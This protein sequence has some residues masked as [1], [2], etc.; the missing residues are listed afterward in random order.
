MRRL[1][2]D[3]SG[4][5]RFIVI[6]AGL[7]ILASPCRAQ[8]ATVSGFV[9]DASDGQPL[10]GA[11]VALRDPADGAEAVPRYG[12]AANTDGLYLVR[13]IQ[14]GRYALTIS[15]IGYEAFR[16]TLTLSQG[17]A[18]NRNVAL[19]PSE[20]T[21]DELLVQAERQQSMG[22]VTAGH[23]RIRPAEI[24]LIPSPDISADL[25]SYLTTL[26]G[27][28]T[29]GDRGGQFFVRGG[30]PSQNLILL[31]GIVLYQ[32]FHVIGSYS[33]FPAD[34][35]SGVDI[36]AGGFGPEYAGRLSSVI[37]VGAREGNNR[38][39]AGHVS[40]SPF[41]ASALV[42][43]PV[44][45]GRLSFIGS[46]RESLIERYG[47][48]LYA[49]E[50]PFQFRDAFGKLHF[51]PS[52]RS[53]VA[54]S[55]I[56]TYD[57][58]TLVRPVSG[59][60][61]QEV[62]WR[63]N[64]W[65]ARWLLLPRLLDVAMDVR[66]ARSTHEMQQGSPQD[67]VRSTT[68]GNTR[69]AWRASLFHGNTTSEAGWDAVFSTA[70]NQ[71]GGLFQNVDSSDVQL[72][73]I[74]FFYEP[75]FLFY[76]VRLNVGLRAQWYN[77]RFEPYLEPRLR[78]VWNRG[79]HQVSAA[80]GL[81]HQEIVGLYDRRDAASVFTAW[82][83]VPRVKQESGDLPE[84]RLPR[85]AHGIVGYRGTPATW[86]TVSLE[87][88]YKE[89][90]NLFVS[91]WTA[92]PRFTT[93]LQPA[94]GRS[95]GLDARLELRRGA[96]YG[97]IN[98]GLSS[99]VYAAEDAALQLW[100]GVEKLR[101]RP[102]H[103]RRHQVNALVSTSLAG[104]DMSARWSFGSGLPFSRAVGFDGFIPFDDFV[105][106]LEE[107]GTPRVIYERPYNDVLPTYHRLDLSVER[108]FSAAV[109]DITLFGSVMNL[110]DRRNLF[111][112]DIF[113]LR[114]T[115]QLPIVPSFGIKITVE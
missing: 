93:R 67:T 82:I 99:S 45:P 97:Y 13:N 70:Q 43:G 80:A 95:L 23:Q 32:P 53:R 91:E 103:D 112:V 109:A 88:F 92:Y 106:V 86:L 74:G 85:A 33:A 21:L 27:I 35:I 39:L 83:N 52:R 18:L 7:V 57:R 84:A 107:P 59:E 1:P 96:F 48:S 78:V 69:I 72:R 101:F 24:E 58:G 14:P 77:V 25:A 81:Y 55:G 9:T 28:V 104:F 4:Y 29:S 49:R 31:D 100:Y 12:T 20:S 66:V 8:T 87:G 15:F 51:A 76:G 113:T 89:L 60:E 111:Y 105:D 79:S 40:V 30:E 5:G 11:T 6:L 38:R 73:S 26:P 16:D 64:G 41:A 3:P 50:M 46:A 44:I 36:Y 94:T 42:E 61:A 110:Y 47:E 34:I 102:P 115:D 56:T 108:S 63:N 68:V 10:E 98:Y 17:D 90:S 19:T 37:D 54:I 65:G 62:R 114:R 22:R 71:L 75:E 2:I